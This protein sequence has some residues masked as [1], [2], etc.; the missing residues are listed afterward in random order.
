M[1]VT[2]RRAG[3]RRAECDTMAVTGTAACVLCLCCLLLL[4]LS[5][6]KTRDQASGRQGNRRP[7]RQRTPSAGDAWLYI[8]H[9]CHNLPFASVCFSLPL[10][11][12]ALMLLSVSCVGHF[13]VYPCLICLCLS[14]SV[15]LSLCLSLSVCLSVC[16]SLVLVI[17]VCIRV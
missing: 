13:C 5:H 14:V 15:S 17:S 12:H 8:M 6:A 16:L 11:L 7:G 9:S 1:S 4:D 3:A 2:Q 10:V